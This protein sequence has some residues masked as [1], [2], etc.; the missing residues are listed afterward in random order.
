LVHIEAHLAQS[1][2]RK[3]NPQSSLLIMTFFFDKLHQKVIS[4]EK[5]CEGS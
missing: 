3:A 2:H 4:R 5:R 1:G